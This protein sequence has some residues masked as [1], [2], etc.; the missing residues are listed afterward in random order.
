MP[1]V[2]PIQ[3]DNKPGGVDVVIDESERSWFHDNEWLIG[4]IY[5]I[6]GPLIALFGTAWFPQITACLVSV[7]VFSTGLTMCMDFGWCA[8][9]GGAIGSSIAIVTLALLAGVL[10][11]KNIFAMIGLLGLVA[12]FYIGAFIFTI[13]AGASSWEAAWGY[14]FFACTFAIAGTLMACKFG[15]PIVMTCTALVGSY[16]FMRAWTLFFPGY[17]PS[18]S[19]IVSAAGHKHDGQDDFQ[20]TGMFWLFI[21]IFV[22]AFGFAMTF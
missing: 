6:V 22:A 14:W 3:Y 5:L 1:T 18:E 20:M 7:F 11:R 21:A 16:L 9:T 15:V 8:T 4:I 13:I 12:G 10:V 17:Y 19:Q 2:D